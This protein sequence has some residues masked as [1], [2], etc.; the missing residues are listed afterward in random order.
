[1][2]ELGAHTFTTSVREHWWEK[3]FLERHGY[4]E[5][6]R[7][8]QSVLDLRQIDFQQFRAREMEALAAGVQI[9]PLSDLGEFN[10]AK[11]RKLYALMASV[12]AD[13]PSRTPI[14]VW[15]FPIWQQ[16]LL[17]HLRPEGLFVAVSP[18]GDWVGL[19]E[20]YQPIESRPGTVHNGLTGVL[21]EWRGHSIGLALKLSAARA[22]LARGYT[23][24]RTTN[25]S[26]NRPMLAINE[27]LGFQKESATV[28]MIK[29]VRE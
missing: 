17:P 3:E 24:S 15:P 23:H 2:R 20:L 27:T 16:R 25:H 29:T 11:Q 28:T 12:L 4:A 19:S 5:H 26:V 13:V 6:D 18:Q 1:M 21:R 7:R 10:E 14:S 9:R 8:W 22:A